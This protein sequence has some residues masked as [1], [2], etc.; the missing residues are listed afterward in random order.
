MQSTTGQSKKT[1]AVATLG[2]KVNKYDSQVIIEQFQNND[3][4]IVDFSQRAD[5][6]IINTCT[7]TKKSNKE[8]RRLIRNAFKKNSKARIIVTGCYA[9]NSPQEILRIEGV[10]LVINNKDKS[11]IFKEYQSFCQK[12]EKISLP[13]SNFHKTSLIKDFSQKSRAFVK[14]QDGCNQFCSYCIVP[15]VRGRSCSKPINDIQEEIDLLTAK[16]FKEI[17]LVGINLGQYGKD[18]SSSID[19]PKVIKKLCQHP[20]LYRLRL[21]SINIPD[22]SE[23]L[24]DLVAKDSKICKHLHIP[25]QSGSSF[26][27]KKMNRGYTSKEYEKLINYLKSRVPGIGITTDI[28]VGF[29]GEED[30]HFNETYELVK[31]LK[32]SRTHIFRYSPRP[33]TK[34]CLFLNKVPDK[35][36]KQRSDTL[37][38]LST[39]NMIYFMEKHKEERVKVL[40]EEYKPSLKLYFG[41]SSNYIRV[42]VRSL[43]TIVGK[44]IEVSVKEIKKDYMVGELLPSISILSSYLFCFFFE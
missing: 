36:K 27:L 21:S 43:R 23:E 42:G 9:Q 11:R 4:N 41:Y 28:L 10:S 25:L 15:F 26:I 20:K 29:P 12:K 17:V 22:I 44:I 2:C 30:V 33:Y 37:K 8:S 40:I 38:E 34:A 5:I 3:L 7:V 24:I 1:F 19:L 31:E 16:G 35:I 13:R 6:Y 32:F 39:Q 18:I 14:I